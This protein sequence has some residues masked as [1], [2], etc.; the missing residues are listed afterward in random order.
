MMHTVK[1]GIVAI[2]QSP[3]PKYGQR[4]SVADSTLQVDSCGLSSACRC[5]RKMFNE[6]QQR[7]K[8]QLTITSLF[9]KLL[10][11]FAN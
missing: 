10:Y 1:G 7:R 11:A 6:Q 8:R 2:S 5:Y 4:R 9:N 3:A